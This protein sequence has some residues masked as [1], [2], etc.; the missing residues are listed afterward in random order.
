MLT[1]RCDDVATEG[2]IWATF[3]VER[4]I[5]GVWGLGD[6]LA[7]GVV[8]RL[9]LFSQLWVRENCGG[10]SYGIGKSIALIALRLRWVAF[11]RIAN[12]IGVRDAVA[13]ASCDV[14]VF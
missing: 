1:Q 13:C 10:L 11:V 3:G 8:T 12:F 7:V 6:L 2:G 9:P 4:E 14:A 5:V